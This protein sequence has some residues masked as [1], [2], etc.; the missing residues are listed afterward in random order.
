MTDATMSAFRCWSAES[1]GRTVFSDIGALA[2]DADAVFLAAHT[3][4]E[5]EHR[6]GPELGTRRSGEAQVLEALTSRVGDVERNTL[7][8]VTGASGSGKSHVVRWV[9]SHLP[10]DDP[11]YHIL[12]VPRAIQ[13]LRELLRRII[14]GL[15]GVE[16]NELMRRVDEAISNVKPGELQARLVNEIK[17]A[18]DWN[19]EDRAPFDGETPAEAAAREDRNSMLG[20]KDSETGGRHDGLAE[21]LDMAQFKNALLRPDGRLNLLVQSYFDERSRRD[22]NDIFT[23]ADLPLRERGIRPALSGRRDLADLWTVITRTPDDALAVLEEALRV[24]LP[25]TVGLRSA[26]GETLDSLF[27]ASRKALRAQ[28]RDLV[29][30]FEDLAQFGLVD[31]ELYD[32]FVTQPGDDLAPLRVLFAITHGPYQRLERTVRTRIEHEFHV[33]GSALTSPEQFVGRYLNLVRVGREQTQALWKPGADRQPGSNWMANACDTIEQ[34][35]PCRFRDV[36]HDAFGAVPIEGL[37]DVGLYPYNHVALQ[38]AIAHLGDNPT[39]RDVL[40][41]CVS[42]V[43]ME[44]DVHI[45]SGSYPHERTRQQF[46]FKVRMAKDALQAANPSSD[47]ERIYRALVIWGDESPLPDGILTAFSLDRKA[48]TPPPTPPQTPPDPDSG[49]K[50]L[51]NPLQPLFQW[52]VGGELPEDDVTFY[53]DTLRRLTLDRLQLDEY[54]VH[55]HAG[56]G[57]EILDG[58]FNV[59]SFAIEGSR[60]RLAGPQSVRFNIRRA[61]EDVQVLA[62]ARWFRVHG[63]FDPTQ[64]KIEWPQG[65]DPAQLAVQLE[66][67][68]D[69]WAAEVR[70]EFLELTGGSRL[71]QQAVGLR[72]VA[73]AASGRRPED[74]TATAAVLSPPVDQPPRPGSAWSPVDV[75]ASS[76]I[77]TLRVNDY[78]GE[79]AAVRQGDAGAPQLIDPRLLDSAIKSFMANPLDQLDAVANSKA[80]PVLTQAAQRLLAALRTAAPQEAAVASRAHAAVREL[81]EGRST[82]SVSRLAEDVGQMARDAGVFRP[83]EKWSDFRA[84]IAVVSGLTAVSQLDMDGSNVGAVLHNQRAA[85]ET[86]RLE[87]SLTLIKQVMDATR[88]ECE[89]AGGVG[90][91]LL[92]IRSEVRAQVEE[93]A[94]LVNS[95]GGRPRS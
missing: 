41:T 23:P 25:K 74:L 26:G 33:G 14:D 31:G 92:K 71:A 82:G 77:A 93:L 72:A 35:M 91:D 12:Y 44:A 34:G 5:L 68:L 37:G 11:R 6:K 59:T 50:A 56:R 3:P 49:R 13:T 75:V 73:L 1:V 66:D 27:R 24:A 90:G 55:V 21:L 52:Q 8:A 60:G 19:L 88:R 94:Q 63:H 7:V 58:I 4:I 32:Q 2:G 53:R 69:Q 95:L 10:P 84:A 17:I 78:V 46:D 87:E 45:G 80:D 54:L 79:F 51:S 38:R 65:Y 61:A 89:R 30:V 70:T 20:E 42:T 57:K 62:A 22:D 86:Y 85:R 47:P 64:A 43:L 81:L 39:P 67:R 76:I 15:P 36:C 29:L 28:G 9:H 18:L 83:A 40:D 48:G 16:G